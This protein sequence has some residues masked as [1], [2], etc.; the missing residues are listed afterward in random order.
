MF[1]LGAGCW[2]VWRV[3]NPGD[4]WGPLHTFMIGGVLLAISGATQLFSITW[5]AAIP[6]DRRL[7]NVQRWLIVTGAATVVGAAT[8]DQD[9]VL[10]G[11]AILVGLGLV[12]LAWILVGV[13]RRSLLGRFGLSTRFY[14][15]AIAAGL[16][17]VTLGAMA[18]IGA[19]G[20]RYIDFRVSHMHLNLVGLVGFT[21]VGT[22]PTILP[23]MARHTMVSGRE[24]IVGFWFSVFALA[25]MA[26]GA[27]LGSTTVGV[28]S[29]LA[30]VGAAVTLMGILLRLGIRRIA[31]SGAPGLLVT[32]GSLW[33][34]G[35][36]ITQFFVLVGG[37]HVVWSRITGIG[38]G[39]IAL[40]LF[41]S[42]SYLIPV[43]AGPGSDLA[44]NFARM[45]NNQWI[46]FILAN[47]TVVAVAASLAGWVGLVM[48]VAFVVD[49]GVRVA[50]VVLRSRPLT[51]RVARG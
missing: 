41:G 17:G 45:R 33:L 24:A 51:G 49:F 3:F 31:A 32:S 8:W 16:L 2:A 28:G 20:S 50:F 29:G 23:T 43:L 18:R 9:G 15:L 11:S 4:W 26:A 27:A 47:G 25:A 14:L 30:G 36:M 7:A 37:D 48:A 6:P 12:G 13:T 21:I 40:V 22:L 1:I 42:L 34:I 46:R 39:G 5:A 19:A 38:V 44:G 35:W 10:I